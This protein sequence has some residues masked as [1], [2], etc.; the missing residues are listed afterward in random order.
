MSTILA[1]EWLAPVGGSENVFERLRRLYPQA[2][3]VCLWNDA[4]GRFDDVEETWLAGSPFRRS[5][6]LAFPLLSRAWRS[7]DQTGVDRVIASAH[8]STHHF[9]SSAA[10]RGVPSFAYVHTPPRY[11]WAPEH[12][13]RGQ[14]WLARSARSHFQR[15][16]RRRTSGRVSFAANSE[17][18][19]ERMAEAWGVDAT[20]LYPPV[21]VEK[22]QSVADWREMVVD[23]LELSRLESLPKDFVLGASRLVPYKRLDAAITA[24]NRLG[25][26][27]V[28]VGS[29][30]DEERLRKLAH[31]SRVPVTFFGRASTPALYALYQLTALFVFLAIED[32]GIM[33]V[34]AMAAGAP[35]A[36]A[37]VGGA[38]ESVEWSRGGVVVEDAVALSDLHQVPAIDREQVTSRASRFSDATFDEAVLEWAGR[39]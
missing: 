11:I 30:P 32:F 17:F 31:E 33:P 7:V 25:L 18:I 36:V 27:V 4:P 22:I 20:V 38:R 5:K 23:P 12:D 16:D 28:I 3:S 26:P 34:E 2:R 19:R 29:G 13:P 35:V 24:G 10:E 15:L 6:A 1:H 9:A 14:S 21:S 37:A 39:P 8:A